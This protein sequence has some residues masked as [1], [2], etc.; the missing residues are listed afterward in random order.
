VDDADYLRHDAI[1]LAALVA[2]REV[3]PT[4]LLDAAQRISAAVNPRVNAVTSDLDAFAREEIA[5]GLPDGPFRGVP[6]LLK[7][8]YQQLAGTV[9]TH[10]CRAFVGA[11]ADHDST[12]TARYR[13]AGL[14][15]FGK[16]NTPELA[17]AP[18][19]E[20]ALFGPS[21]N[22]WDLDRSTGGSSGGAAAAV[23]AGIVPAAHA[24]DGGGSIRIPAAACGLVGLKPTRGRVPLGPKVFENWAGATCAHVVTRTVRD[25]AALLDATAGP[26]L[27]DSY[28]CHPHHGTFLAEL[29]HEPRPL[30]VALMLEPWR[31]EIEVDPE[32][33]RAVERTAATL[34]DLGH[35]VE[36]A[37]PELD[38]DPLFAAFGTITSAGMAAMLDR[39]GI[40][41]GAAIAEE[42]L[43]PVGWFLYQRGRAVTGSAY[44]DAITSVQAA[45]RAAARF[46][47]HWD[48]L[49]CPTVATPAPR[50]GE[51]SGP[52]AMAALQAGGRFSPFAAVMN[53]TGQ[54]SISLPLARS[55]AGLPIG[56]M[57][58]AALG[59]EGLLLRLARQLE[60]AT[61]WPTAPASPASPA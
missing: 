23:A 26:E 43:E 48:V 51:M 53:L 55:A 28:L 31:R 60:V 44:V 37:R 8:Q 59:H 40:E 25:T 10:G 21:R 49:L 2:S 11:V 12:L 41:R 20:P 14:V 34:E 5:H 6:F 9:T 46:H 52:D 61:P 15:I 17:M 42:D 54:P 27:G 50:L 1:G 57:C 45:T 13:A 22:P 16:T 18:T 38:L 35:H 30:R 29:D 24:S 33:R 39:R 36:P 47:E 32:V 3:T 4:E 58:T 56:V 7:D 19:T